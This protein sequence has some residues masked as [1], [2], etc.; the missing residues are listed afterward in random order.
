MT[1]VTGEEVG[2]EDFVQAIQWLAKFFYAIEESIGVDDIYLY[3]H[4]QMYPP[5][6]EIQINLFKIRSR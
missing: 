2:L 3:S 6:D 1:L 5:Q 4:C